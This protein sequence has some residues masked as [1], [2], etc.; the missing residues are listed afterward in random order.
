MKTYVELSLVALLILVLYNPVFFH[1]IIAKNMITKLLLVVSIVVMAQ[2]FGMG[3]GLLMGIIAIVIMHNAVEGL[4]N[5]PNSSP[6]CA[7]QCKDCPATSLEQCKERCRKGVS[8]NGCVGGIF[9]SDK[10]ENFD[11]KICDKNGKKCKPTSSDKHNPNTKDALALRKAINAAGSKKKFEQLAAQA[12]VNFNN[13]VE[14]FTTLDKPEDFF[15]LQ[16]TQKALSTNDWIMQSMRRME[17][18]KMA[19]GGTLVATNH[20]DTNLVINDEPGVNVL[21]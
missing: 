17:Q 13:N 20:L 3:S 1:N 8:K 4:D 12:G 15:S 5:S 21:F 6:V 9:L 11:N 18:A 2:Y 19:P 10:R 7:G 14:S 16:S